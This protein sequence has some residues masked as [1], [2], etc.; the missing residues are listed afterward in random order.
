MNKSIENEIKE[1]YA[2]FFI[3]EDWIIFKNSAE[4]YLETAARILI[5]DILYGSEKLKLLRRN[6]QKRLFTGIAC[7]LILKAFFLKNGYCI[8]KV[9]DNITLNGR[10]PFKLNEI[11]KKDFKADDTVTFNKLM[12]ALF[13]IK[14]FRSHKKIINKG[15]RIAKVFRNKEGHVVVIW[16]SYDPQNYRDIENSL[17]EFYKIAFGETLKLHFSVG[18]NEKAEFEILR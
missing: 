14:D 1:Q 16:H 4:Y 13:C 18:E 6:I 17:I 5:K 10:F 8:N 3:E 7:E 11:N 12:E 9:K 15:L 2:K